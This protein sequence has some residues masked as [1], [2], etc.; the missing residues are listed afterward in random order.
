M[1]IVADTFAV[2]SFHFVNIFI[3]QHALLHNERGNVMLFDLTK[4]VLYYFNRGISSFFF[5]KSVRCAGLLCIQKISHL[6]K[7][8]S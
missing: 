8:I 2:F 1:A 7:R 6:I 3:E 4:L 5:T